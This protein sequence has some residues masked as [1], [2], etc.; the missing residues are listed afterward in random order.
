MHL[1]FPAHFPVLHAIK[2]RM[3]SDSAEQGT[4]LY[5][6]DGEGD[7][8][9]NRQSL[10]SGGPAERAQDAQL[11]KFCSQLSFINF[12]K[13]GEGSAQLCNLSVLGLVQQHGDRAEPKLTSF[14]WLPTQRER[15]GKTPPCK[16]G[17]AHN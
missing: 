6:T 7:Q 14:I 16:S 11:S 4:G 17:L 2:R 1:V 9:M 13:G 5:C 12:A 10:V 3:Q 8:T 15:E